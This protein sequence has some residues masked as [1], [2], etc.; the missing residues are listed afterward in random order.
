MDAWILSPLLTLLK[1]TS[2]RD[3][4]NM[5]KKPEILYLGEKLCS[6]VRRS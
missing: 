2:P 1:L 3:P 6:W 4:A 5:L